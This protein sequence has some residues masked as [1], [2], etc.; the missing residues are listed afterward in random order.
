MNMNSIATVNW[1]QKFDKTGTIFHI[2]H[3][4]HS[5]AIAYGAY[6]YDVHVEARYGV[7]LEICHVFVDSTVFKQ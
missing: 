4:S 1:F 7:G 6:I 5:F 3:L 2:F